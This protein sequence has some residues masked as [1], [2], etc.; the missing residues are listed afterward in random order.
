MLSYS[1]SMNDLYSSKTY[2]AT[3]DHTGFF[4]NETVYNFVKNIINN[5]VNLIP[6][7]SS[8]HSKV[9]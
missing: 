5:N 4:K 1:A 9:M 7:I 8:E 6:G 2:F 3:I